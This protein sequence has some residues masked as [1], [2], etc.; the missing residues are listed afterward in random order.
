M[1]KSEGVNQVSLNIKW[2]RTFCDHIALYFEYSV[3]TVAAPNDVNFNNKTKEILVVI[4]NMMSDKSLRLYCE[5][6]DFLSEDFFSRVMSYKGMNS[7]K[8]VQTRDLYEAYDFV[9]RRVRDASIKISDL[10]VAFKNLQAIGWKKL[11]KDVYQLDH[12]AFVDR[13][14][15]GKVRTGE[16]FKAMKVTRSRFKS[17]LQYCRAVEKQ[18]KNAF[19]SKLLPRLLSK[20]SGSVLSKWFRRKLTFRPV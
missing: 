9:I 10:S 11:C 1:L 19:H 12:Q 17:A 8:F 4:W 2:G 13:K 16:H 3:C 14:T 5:G 18:T 15:N 20:N 6:L 7:S